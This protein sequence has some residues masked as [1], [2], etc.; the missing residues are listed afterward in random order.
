MQ[1][2]PPLCRRLPDAGRQRLACCCLTCPGPLPSGLLPPPLLLPPPA[3]PCSPQVSPEL[4]GPTLPSK[5]DEEF[6]PFVR[7]LPEFKFWCD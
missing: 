1:S 7:R 2:P 5:S 3:A 6:R 4:D